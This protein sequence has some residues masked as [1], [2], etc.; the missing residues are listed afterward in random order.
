MQCFKF[1][2][3]R[4][5]ICSHSVEALTNSTLDRLYAWLV[6]TVYPTRSHKCKNW[7]YSSYYDLCICRLVY[8]FHSLHMMSHV[9]PAAARSV[10]INIGIV[11]LTG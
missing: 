7:L 6:A 9:V 11:I 8:I 3:L 5:P 1:G 4:K 10:N 2:S